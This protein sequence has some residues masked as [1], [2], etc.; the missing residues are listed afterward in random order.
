MLD[1]I[2]KDD[3]LRFVF[4]ARAAEG[5]DAPQAEA[6]ANVLKLAMHIPDEERP[7]APRA[8]GA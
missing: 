7:E 6:I 8:L 3:N 2:T 4:D 5:P 1:V